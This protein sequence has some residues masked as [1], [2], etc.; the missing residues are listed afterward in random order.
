MVLAEG[1]DLSVVPE[2]LAQSQ[3]GDRLHG[4]AQQ[5]GTQRRVLTLWEWLPLFHQ[6]IH[7]LRNK[8]SVSRK[9][10]EVFGFLIYFRKIIS[11]LWKPWAQAE[12]CF[13]AC[14]WWHF[15]TLFFSWW[16]RWPHLPSRTCSRAATSASFQRSRLKRKQETADLCIRMF[17]FSIRYFSQ[18]IPECKKSC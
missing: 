10:E 7:Q 18:Q 13:S 8:I 15:R 16:T 4:Q 9:C 5:V 3:L 6:L 14:C 1:K 11:W 17:F 12:S 2:P